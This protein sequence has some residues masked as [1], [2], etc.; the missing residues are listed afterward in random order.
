M[1]MRHLYYSNGK[2]IIR[3]LHN[4]NHKKTS[5]WDKKEK[6][7]AAC[8]RGL[9]TACNS[10][11]ETDKHTQDLSTHSRGP[12]MCA[13]W[14]LSLLPLSGTCYSCYL[15]CSWT[16]AL[17]LTQISPTFDKLVV[18]TNQCIFLIVT[19]FHDLLSFKR[20]YNFGLPVV[21]LKSIEIIVLLGHFVG[22]QGLFYPV[23]CLSGLH[24]RCFGLMIQMLWHLLKKKA[25]TALY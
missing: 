9:V 5:C 1:F 21:S 22:L 20:C 10:E 6:E 14:F 11:T 24:V 19:L 18:E 2:L 16:W 17:L 15:F 7:K 12:S 8:T 4:C 13:W 3:G 23:S 25:K